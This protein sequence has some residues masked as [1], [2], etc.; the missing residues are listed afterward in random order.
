MERQQSVVSSRVVGVVLLAAIAQVI[1]T[2]LTS[3]AFQNSPFDSPVSLTW[4]SMHGLL[5]LGVPYLYQHRKQIKA[6]ETAT[7]F[8]LLEPHRATARA[9][10]AVNVNDTEH[11]GTASAANG[12]LDE[13][14]RSASSRN[15]LTFEAALISPSVTSLSAARKLLF[16]YVLYVVANVAYVRALGGLSPM[17]VSAIFCAA[18]GIVL[19]LSWPVLGQAIHR[20]EV[21]CVVGGVS[22]IVCITQP[23]STATNGDTNS[24]P[25]VLSLVAAMSPCAAAVYKVY[26]SKFFTDASWQ[27][28]GFQL[29]LLALIN[30][31]L[32]TIALAVFL[33]CGGETLPWERPPIPWVYI[34]PSVV[35]SVAF[36]FFV[37]YGVTITYPLF[38]SMASLLGTGVNIVINESGLVSA[39]SS[40][41]DPLRWVGVA[42]VVSSLVM[43][44]AFTW[45][46]RK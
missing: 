9:A 28:V 32:G 42:L 44:L 14:Q 22:G 36:N 40:G 43:L 2:Q 37:N 34:L 46:K 26:F 4:F 5:L 20:V 17:L 24:H 21:F 7:A 13:P 45:F 15:L 33:A 31:T 27:F 11:F 1:S 30:A 19:L 18:P 25:L 39:A 38:V 23:W 3:L 8:W 41:M 35:A 16:L 6:C 29:S 10:A 12:D